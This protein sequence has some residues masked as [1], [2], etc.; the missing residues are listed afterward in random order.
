MAERIG[1]ECDDLRAAAHWLERQTHEEIARLLEL[2]GD[3]DLNQAGKQRAPRDRQ[4]SAELK[5]ELD[6]M[7][8]EFERGD[9]RKPERES[10]T[11][12]RPSALPFPEGEARPEAESKPSGFRRLFGRR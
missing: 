3:N 8:K 10:P 7:V 11:G 2:A 12:V 5:I 4:F 1:H 9:D 6:R